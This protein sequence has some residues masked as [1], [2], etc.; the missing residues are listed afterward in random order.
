ARL[1]TNIALNRDAAEVDEQISRIIALAENYRNQIPEER[2]SR[3][4][5][6]SQQ[7]I[8]DI[9]VDNSF[10]RARYEEAYNYLEISN[11]R[12]LL[13]WLKKGVSIK[14][15]KEK[16]KEIEVIFN[17][18]AQPLPLAEIRARMPEGVQ[19]LQYAVLENKVLLWL[20]SKDDFHHTV[21]EIEAEKLSEKIKAYTELVSAQD[22]KK[23][24]EAK[25]LAAELYDLLIR[26]VADRLDAARQICV[27]PHKALFNLPFAALT[28][29]DG[30]PFLKQFNFFYAPSANVFLLFTEDARRKSAAAEADESLLSVGNPHFD[31]SSGSEFKNLRDLPKAEVEA[32]EIVPLYAADSKSL[33]GKAATE[34]A[35]QNSLGSAEVIHFAGHYMVRDGEPLASGLL[36]TRDENGDKPDD[37]IL[38]NAEL[39]SRKMPQ[40]RL[41]VLSACRT[42]VEQY[43]DGEGMVGL[44]RTF[45]AAGAPLVVA[46]HWQVDSGATAVLMKDFHSFRRR[47]K[48][49]TTAALR[50]AQLKMLESADPRLRQ[51]YYWAAFAAYGGYAEF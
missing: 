49:S 6:S 51:P 50:R 4:F 3:S 15:E 1:Q 13:N 2:A 31:R 43:Y 14:N 46:S 44:S 28:S 22:D 5:F 42:G 11:S 8:Y 45:L 47:E 35:L 17:E 24:E 19:I 25:R 40:A 10:R 39:I 38:T 18:N 27:I 12:S 20:V 29:A 36:L 41:V 7:D 30:N 16:I 21:T 26:P 37:G 48:L 33:L 9:A 23:Q 34:S 32:L